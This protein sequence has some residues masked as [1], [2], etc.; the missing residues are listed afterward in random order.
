MVGLRQS[1]VSELPVSQTRLFIFHSIRSGAG[2]PVILE[3]RTAGPGLPKLIAFLGTR[4]NVH[5]S[6]FGIR[7]FYG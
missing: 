7:N 3:L 6:D 4:T 2:R 1:Y 5:V